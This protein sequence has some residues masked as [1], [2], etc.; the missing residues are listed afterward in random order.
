MEA[1]LYS[2]ARDKERINKGWGIKYI[3]N[4]PFLILREEYWGESKKFKLNEE[5]Y[6]YQIN[7]SDYKKNPYN[8]TEYIIQRDI[9][10]NPDDII[11]INFDDIKS[12]IIYKNRE[13]WYKFFNIHL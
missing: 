6:V 13:D 2:M 7:A 11:I 1:K 3:D 4:K 5:G 8:D 12:N 10:I 9:I